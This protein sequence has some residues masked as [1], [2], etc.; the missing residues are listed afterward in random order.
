MT[1]SS[2]SSITV[3]A[4]R[5]AWSPSAPIP[6]SLV[7][8]TRSTA[9]EDRCGLGAPAVAAP[10]REGAGLVALVGRDEE[11]GAVVERDREGEEDDAEQAEEADGHPDVVAGRVRPEQ[12]GGDAGA[13][14]HE[15]AQ[16]LDGQ[17]P[18]DAPPE[19]HAERPERRWPVAV[20]LAL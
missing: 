16:A 12:G 11:A 10:L 5:S 7:R 1:A 4:R 17:R 20:E 9:A 18:A 3:S 8:R 2:T 14:Q 15:D 13:D 19:R 6:S